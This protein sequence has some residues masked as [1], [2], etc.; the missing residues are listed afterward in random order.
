MINVIKKWLSKQA[1]INKLQFW[2]YKK[3]WRK[4]NSDN[5]TKPL[6][7]I[8]LDLV[9]IGKGSYGNIQALCLNSDA[10]L[11][12]GCYCSIA[13]NVMFLLSVDHPTNRLSTYP[14]KAF[15]SGEREALTR[16]DIVI[17]DDVWIGYGAIILSGAKIGQGAIIG[18]G[19]VVTKDV[20]P[21]AVVGGVPAK[22]V[23]YR[24]NNEIINKMLKIDWST[25]DNRIIKSNL[26][27][28][29]EEIS[30]ENVDEII[31]NLNCQ[32]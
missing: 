27:F 2:L 22:V 21:Y 19:A 28:F 31:N 30:K 13:D 29:Y 7:Y 5:F 9:R 15:F 23:K 26:N 10:R 4:A 17:G 20:P 24:F 11:Y 6:I 16:G 14:F 18:A 32:F 1:Q 12:I 25:I 8:P 3:K